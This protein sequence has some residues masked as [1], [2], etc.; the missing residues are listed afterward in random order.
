MPVRVHQIFWVH[1]LFFLGLAFA[2]ALGRLFGL[3]SCFGTSTSSSPSPCST[4]C[5]ASTLRLGFLAIL[6]NH[7]HAGLLSSCTSAPAT[8]TTT[9]T[10]TL[11]TTS[12]V[13]RVQPV[14]RA[15]FPLQF[16]HHTWSLPPPYEPPTRR[17]K[18]G[19]AS[20]ASTTKRRALRTRLALPPSPLS[21]PLSSLPLSLSPPYIHGPGHT[22]HQPFARMGTLPSHKRYLWSST[23]P[24]KPWDVTN[25]D[26]STARGVGK[27]HPKARPPA[28]RD[29]R[30]HTEPAGRQNAR[31]GAG[32]Q[33]SRPTCAP[34]WAFLHSPKGP[35]RRPL[36][37]R[38]CQRKHPAP[39]DP[40]L[41]AKRR[42]GRGAHSSMGGGRL[43][44]G[45]WEEGVMGDSA[46]GAGGRT[47][48]TSIALPRRGYFCSHGTPTVPRRHNSPS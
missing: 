28:D 14:P 23:S 13:L 12:R 24:Q 22:K 5:S 15:A 2:L 29:P 35:G 20:I 16:L 34:L 11:T 3:G 18:P 10:N 40:R 9:P 4:A 30:N 44:A 1:S 36:S 8:T 21:L 27:V 38:A 42:L 37:S 31:H 6:L 7:C 32:A 47:C 43:A 17:F 41:G 48:P 45:C 19:T 46:C 25:L 33:R 26:D 39:R